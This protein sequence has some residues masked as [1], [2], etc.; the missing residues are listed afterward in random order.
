MRLGDFTSEKQLQAHIHKFWSDEYT[1]MLVL[2]A[3]DALDRDHISLAKFHIDKARKAALEARTNV[4]K[5]V[6]II[7]H[8]QQGK[9]RFTRFTFLCGWKQLTINRLQREPIDLRYKL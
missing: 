5:H 7:I 4:K 1:N 3:D 6:L 8:V 2:Q 9:A